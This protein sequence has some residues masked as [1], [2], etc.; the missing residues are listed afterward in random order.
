MKGR[1][2]TGL[3]TSRSFSQRDSNG[4]ATTQINR[5]RNLR[6]DKECKNKEPGT[7]KKTLLIFTLILNFS[8]GFGQVIK[9]PTNQI[10]QTLI[11]SGLDSAM[12]YFRNWNH[13]PIY[14][15]DMQL[16]IDII[17]KIDL[18]SNYIGFMLDVAN[19]VQTKRLS[20]KSYSLFKNHCMELRA[21]ADNSEYAE[22]KTLD[23]SYLSVLLK[24]K[25][26][27]LESLLLDNY[28]YWKN[29]ISEVQKISV[30]TRFVKSLRGDYLFEDCHYNC[31]ITLL[32]LKKLNSKFYSDSLEY[33][34]RENVRK[35]QKDNF[36]GQGIYLYAYR[37]YDEVIIE[38][39]RGYKNLGEID[40]ETETEL[41]DYIERFPDKE[42][43]WK[44]L[45]YNDRNGI[46]DLGC[47]IAP[48]AGNGKSYRIELIEKNKLKIITIQDWIS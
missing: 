48:L 4:T 9:I 8:S 26:D 46:L 37:E 17:E 13:I 11:D 5:R 23:G 35:F 27:S 25:N 6:L 38:L 33:F 2:L 21:I 3:F 1:E 24:Q 12:N 41:R 29:A 7:M 32:G 10:R 18:E 16:C 15:I 19:N 47:Q 34:H 22:I 44:K 36:L 31:L 45:I 28:Q 43:C 40:F 42:Y 39:N 30:L 20:E 14:R